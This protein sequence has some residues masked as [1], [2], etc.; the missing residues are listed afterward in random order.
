M[1]QVV[2]FNKVFRN[3]NN[4]RK[5]YNVS[6]GGAGS[7]KSVNTAKDFILKLSG[8]EYKGA[9]LLVVRRSET[10][11]NYSTYPELLNAINNCHLLGMWD[12]KTKPLSM[13]NTQNG[14]SIIFKGCNDEKAIERLKSITVANGKLCWVWIE[15]ATEITQKQF[16]IIDDRLRGELSDN[17]F[18]QIKL[19]LNPIDAN[20]WIKHNLWDF[21]SPDIDRVHSTYRDN[22]FVDMQYYERMERRRLLDPQ[23]YKI[24]GLGEWGTLEGIIFTNIE[25]GDYSEK[26][27]DYYTMG[28]DWGFNHKHATLL[29]GWKDSEPYIIDE[30]VCTGRTTSQIITMCEEHNLP[31]D[32]S[33]KMF[34]D[35]AEPDRIKEFGKAGYKVQAVKKYAGSVLDSIS[36]LKDRVIHIDNKCIQLIKEIENYRWQ[37]DKISGQYID[38]PINI[39]DDCI[40]ALRYSCEPEMQG[41]NKLGTMSKIML[42]I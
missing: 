16:D 22:K 9:N 31:K 34:C 3:I 25:K 24:Y 38:E 30:V 14:N 26:Q 41:R 32:W 15:E 17:L 27:F 1:E 29:V 20:H 21:D 8:D 5:R 6:V 2:T 23:G 39:D 7:G 35:S 42:G 13:V 19:T 33:C 10:A 4:S 28:T 11:H 12:T 37:Q 18:Y 36:F 40:S